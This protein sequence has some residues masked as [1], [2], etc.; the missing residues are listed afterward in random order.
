MGMSHCICLVETYRSMCK[1]AYIGHHVNLTFQ[2]H[3]IYGST[4]F[5]EPNT[6]VA[7]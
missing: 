2:G 4:R 6:M 5:D 1:M 3:I 7:K